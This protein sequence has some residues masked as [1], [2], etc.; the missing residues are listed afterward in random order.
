MIEILAFLYRMIKV[1][2]S[3]SKGPQTH[4]ENFV[5]L[6]HK[7]QLICGREVWLYI[8]YPNKTFSV[9]LTN[10]S[11]KPNNILRWIHTENHSSFECDTTK[12]AAICDIPTALSLQLILYGKFWTF[13]QALKQTIQCFNEPCSN[14]V[15]NSNNYY[16]HC[17]SRMYVF[18]YFLILIIFL[19]PH[20]SNFKTK[21]WHFYCIIFAV[22]RF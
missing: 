10:L 3:N 7:V 19:S 4:K 11:L 9:V 17:P 22:W 13:C 6:I 5:T 2:F 15:T 20:G 14:L 21:R 18:F 8:Y 1:I 12:Q 16:W